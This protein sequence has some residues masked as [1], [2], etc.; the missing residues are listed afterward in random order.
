M[1]NS[2]ELRDEIESVADH[3]RK[4]MTDEIS[5]L[6]SFALSD[7]VNGPVYLDSD[8]EECSPFD[9]GAKAFDFSEAIAQIAAYLE[10]VSDLVTH[11]FHSCDSCDGTGRDEYN[12]E[13]CAQCFGE[14][15]CQYEETISGTREMIISAIVGKTLSEYVRG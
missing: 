9:E 2:L 14:G 5:G 7:L 11:D 12:E 6:V 1:F 10:S 3:F 4:G 15:C 8:G 13:D